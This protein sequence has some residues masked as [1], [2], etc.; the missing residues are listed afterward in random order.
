[1]VSGV[2]APAWVPVVVAT[3]PLGQ[4]EA[5]DDVSTVASGAPVG[6]GGGRRAGGDR[7]AAGEQHEAPGGSGVALHAARGSGDHPGDGDG[8][9]H[10]VRSSA[11][12]S[13]TAP[14]GD[15]VDVTPEGPALPTVR[16]SRHQAVGHLAV[17]AVPALTASQTV[18][19][20]ILVVPRDI[21]NLSF[22]CVCFI[23]GTFAIS[24]NALCTG[25][26]P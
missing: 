15:D 21:A 20:R 3:R 24:V 16:A 10:Q 2:G 6:R 13:T 18:A 5:G 11:S 4:G 7:D 25:C 26:G 12:A 17:P 22:A 19:A 14:P 8:G 9:D 23:K 1:M